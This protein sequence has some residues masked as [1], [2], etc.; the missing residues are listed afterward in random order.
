[1]RVAAYGRKRWV[2][3]PP[4]KAAWSAQ[5]AADWVAEEARRRVDGGVAGADGGE[6]ADDGA[7]GGEGADGADGALRCVQEAGDV[8]LLP[9]TWAHAT[10]NEELSV[11]IALEFFSLQ[12][13]AA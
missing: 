8:L 13:A 10:V 7:D 2:L 11:G 3:L 4:P 6:G 9:E 5:P 1:M 12:H